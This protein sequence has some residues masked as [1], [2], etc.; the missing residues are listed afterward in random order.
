MVKSI[1]KNDEYIETR[2]GDI[3]GEHIFG[4]LGVRWFHTATTMALL[5]EVE[6]IVTGA[7]ARVD[8]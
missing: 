4:T 6:K 8:R 5:V 2:T 3:D 7:G 1:G